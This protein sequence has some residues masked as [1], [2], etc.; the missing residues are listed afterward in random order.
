MD[1]RN[2]NNLLS[3]VA[4]RM[5]T[6]FNVSFRNLTQLVWRLSAPEGR[7]FKL[8][9]GH[10][11]E[12]RALDLTVIFKVRKS[13]A[14]PLSSPSAY[15]TVELGRVTED[16]GATV[17]MDPHWISSPNS[18]LAGNGAYLILA[19][20]GSAPLLTQATF[21]DSITVSLNTPSGFQ[22]ELAD[23]LAFD[24]VEAF[25]GFSSPAHSSPADAESP[26]KVELVP[27]DHWPPHIV[28]PK[29][30]TRT[31]RDG[32]TS[33]RATPSELEPIELSDDGPINMSAVAAPPLVY[34]EGETRVVLTATDASGNVASCFFMIDV[35]VQANISMSASLSHQGNEKASIAVG[36]VFVGLC[37]VLAGVL[38]YRA[39]SYVLLLLTCFILFSVV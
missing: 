36:G 27:L 31:M 37:I 12:V 38:L 20:S 16:S 10:V 28:C 2:D 14:T 35:I 1:L 8:P 19:A 22:G 33:Y 25:L 39:K 7:L 9:Q 4:P 32:M 17:A 21:F 6:S 11:G 23:P 15:V 3:A 5:F 29:N 34:Q 30:M 18:G 24:L 26:P 13:S